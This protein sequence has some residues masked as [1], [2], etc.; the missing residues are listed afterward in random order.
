MAVVNWLGKFKFITHG[1]AVALV[2]GAGYIVKHPDLVA[3][4]V[5]AYPKAAILSSAAG[6]ILML[7]HT[8]TK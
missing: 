7:Y 4:V 5:K 8:P 6:A 3:A 1:L 2:A